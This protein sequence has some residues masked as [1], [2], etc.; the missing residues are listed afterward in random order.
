MQSRDVIAATDR[1]AVDEDVGD[2][3]TACR[4]LQ[5]ILQTRAEVVL[6]ELYDVGGW[7]YGIEVEEDVLRAGVS[8]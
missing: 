6:V 8:D 5:G 4:L 1:F 2:R 7:G 3:S